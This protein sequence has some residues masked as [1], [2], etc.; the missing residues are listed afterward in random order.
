MNTYKT[1]SGERVTQT[2]IDNF[3]RV[4]K[5][6]VLQKQLDE[7]GYN[8]CSVCKR[9]DCKPID[10][11]HEIS[12]K[13]AKESGRTELCWDVNNIIPTGRNCHKKQ[14]GLDLKFQGNNIELKP[15]LP[16]LTFYNTANGMK[17]KTDKKK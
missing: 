2:Q 13:K 6:K 8:F 16:N 10:C 4:A 12:V 1:S 15:Q 7:H 3:T 9:N 11:A 14:D 17:V 5:A